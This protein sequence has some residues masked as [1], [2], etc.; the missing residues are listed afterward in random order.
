M[1]V[2]TLSGP[3]AGA[4][5]VFSRPAVQVQLEV[6][7]PVAIYILGC[8][9]RHDGTTAGGSRTLPLAKSAFKLNLKIRVSTSRTSKLLLL[10]INFKLKEMN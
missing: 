6:W 2:G 10:V 4:A 9:W 3:R 1:P 7:L 8:Q 5:A